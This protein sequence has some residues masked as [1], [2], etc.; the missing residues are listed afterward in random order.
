MN[1]D[2]L[3]LKEKRKGYQQEKKKVGGN[4]SDVNTSHLIII[5]LIVCS[6]NQ[7]LITSSNIAGFIF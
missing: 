1:L 6:F 4:I 2:F 5:V 7:L 3:Q